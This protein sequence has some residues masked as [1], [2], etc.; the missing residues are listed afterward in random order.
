MKDSDFDKDYKTFAE[1]AEYARKRAIHSA[2]RQ[3][4]QEFVYWF[5]IAEWAKAIVSADPGELFEY[6]RTTCSFTAK[7]GNIALSA[8]EYAYAVH[9]RQMLLNLG[10]K[11]TGISLNWLRIAAEGLNR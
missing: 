3:E 6:Y 1:L 11:P 7:Q 5:E 8:K 10:K 4:H 2:E 9:C